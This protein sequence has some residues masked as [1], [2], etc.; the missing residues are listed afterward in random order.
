MDE[1]QIKKIDHLYS[2]SSLW[3]SNL[4]SKLPGES[5]GRFEYRKLLEKNLIKYYDFGAKTSIILAKKIS[6]HYFLGV[7]YYDENILDLVIKDLT[8]KLKNN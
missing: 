1:D 4:K 7:E 5:L 2:R 6:D 3:I 8:D